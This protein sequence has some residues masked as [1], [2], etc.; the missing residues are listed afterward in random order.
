MEQNDNNSRWIAKNLQRNNKL[1]VPSWNGLPL[2]YLKNETNGAKVYLLETKHTTAKSVKNVRDVI[3]TIRLDYVMVELSK[4]DYDQENV[5][6]TITCLLDSTIFLLR[7]PIFAS[8]VK[9]WLVYYR[10]LV[11]FI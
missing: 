4:V 7:S 8:F 1:Q 10:F 9:N 3:T 11:Y 2:V 6:K 5:A